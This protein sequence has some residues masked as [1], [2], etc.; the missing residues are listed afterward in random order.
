MKKRKIEI[1]KR[2]GLLGLHRSSGVTHLTLLM[3]QYLRGCLGYKVTVLEKSGRFDLETLSHYYTHCEKWEDGF[4]LHGISFMTKESGAI[5][6][7]MKN[8]CVLIDFGT[9]YKAVMEVCDKLDI[10]IYVFTNAPW[11]QTS[12]SLWSYLEA[13]KNQLKKVAICNMASKKSLK[14]NFKLPIRTSVLGLEPEIFNPSVEAIRLFE[15]VLLL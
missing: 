15:S 2:I 6:E 7:N 8:E 13:N 14:Q 1:C 9:N 10:L 4:I 11:Y 5:K 3:A 12:D